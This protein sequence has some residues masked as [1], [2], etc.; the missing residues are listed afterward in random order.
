MKKNDCFLLNFLHAHTNSNRYE[1]CEFC[2]IKIKIRVR[3]GTAKSINAQIEN[4][5]SWTLHAFLF[6]VF[7]A[8]NT[9]LK[10]TFY[11]ILKS[12]F[13]TF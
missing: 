9:I 6:A 7:D 10:Y 4:Q 5:N 11:K 13:P 3:F 2:D 1:F 12:F 8:P